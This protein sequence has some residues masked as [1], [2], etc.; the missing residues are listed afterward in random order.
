[1]TRYT[2]LWYSQVIKRKIVQTKAF[3]KEIH[4][5]ISKRKLKLED[6]ED[7]K[8]TLT[9]NPEQ[10]D[11][12]PGTGGIRKTRLKS[13][14]KGKRGGFRVCY[15]SIEDKLILFL[16]FIYPK[17]EQENLS[18]QEKTELKQLAEAIKRSIT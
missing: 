18:S 7:F 15:L 3:E 2:T 14:S 10:G 13:V 8:K 16:L 4:S 9:E 5:L 6:F 12:I 11:V 17:N 1:L